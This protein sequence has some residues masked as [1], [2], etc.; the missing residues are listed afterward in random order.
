MKLKHYVAIALLAVTSVV[1]GY[2]Q[3]TWTAWWVYDVTDYGATGDGTTDDSVAIRNCIDAAIATRGTGTGAVRAEVVFPPGT[4]RVTQNDVLMS[5]SDGNDKGV[6]GLKIR[7]FGK[8]VTKIL[9]QPTTVSATDPFVGNLFSA[10]K[11]ARYFHISDMTFESG[12]TNAAQACCFYFFGDGQGNN[13]NQGNVFERL[14]FRGNW[15]RCFGFDGDVDANLNSEMTFRNISGHTAT[16]TDAFFRVG[17]ISGTYNQQNQFLNYWFYDSHFILGGGTLFRFDKG[18]AA[19][20]INGSWS[21]SS[22][23]SPAM[24]FISMPTTNYN[25][26][27]AAQFRF[28]NIRF[29]PKATNHRIIDCNLQMGSVTFESCVDLSALQT[30]AS[31]NYPLH[32]YTGGT[33]WG[34]V[35]IHPTVRYINCHL[36][37]YHSYEGPAAA[38]NRGWFIYEACY[39][40]RGNNGEMCN[41]TQLQGTTAALRWTSGDPRYTFRNCWNI[42][43]L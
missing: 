13:M 7:G 27:S 35:T 40:Y 30:S 29:E 6:Y 10:Y 37:G 28:T 38:A 33:P 43:N 25:N 32:R 41:A 4:Y 24:T 14:N 18:G 9:F 36:T 39:F 11:R 2:A 16:Y 1:T 22:N 15:K 23:T 26:T 31:Y 17:G 34:G 19:N 12:G 8:D 5:A 20:F 3:D 21:A 42:T